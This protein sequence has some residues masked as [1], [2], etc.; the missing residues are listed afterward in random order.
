MESRTYQIPNIS[1]GHCVRTIETELKELEGIRRIE[2]D[3]A[4][5]RLEVAFEPPT[6]EDR[7]LQLL[8]EINYPAA[9]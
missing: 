7:I 5:K 6:T 1:C 2:V 4:Q 8:A 3:Q 9:V